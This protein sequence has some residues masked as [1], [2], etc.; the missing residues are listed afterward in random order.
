MT[1]KTTWITSLF[2]KDINVDLRRISDLICGK[3]HDKDYEVKC[4]AYLSRMLNCY[5]F[6][7]SCT[8]MML[9]AQALYEAWKYTNER[10]GK[11]GKGLSYDFLGGYDRSVAVVYCM[12]DRLL[13][14]VID[15]AEKSGV[16]FNDQI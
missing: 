8:G 13:W 11:D 7:Y 4:R 6:S 3:A 2:K 12:M 15:N 16:F 5:S 1:G 9:L 14:N 10:M